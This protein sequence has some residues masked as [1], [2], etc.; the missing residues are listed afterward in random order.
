[1]FKEGGYEVDDSA[2]YYGLPSPFNPQ[3]ESIIQT[4]IQ[5]LMQAR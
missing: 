3:I 4:S 2:L 5:A 1:M